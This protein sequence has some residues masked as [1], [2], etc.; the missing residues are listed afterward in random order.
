[1]RALLAAGLI[2]VNTGCVIPVA[3]SN[4]LAP[5]KKLEQNDVEVAFAVTIDR[6]IATP[7]QR[8]HAGSVFFGAAFY[9]RYAATDW[10]ALEAD[11]T[12]SPLLP[13]AIP[14]FNGVGAGA[15][16]TAVHD[17]DVK[18]TLEVAPRI[19]RWTGSWSEVTLRNTTIPGGEIV[20]LG[21]EL[22]LVGSFRPVEGVT[23]TMAPFGRYLTLEETRNDQT[24]PDRTGKAYGVGVS[25]S[26]TFLLGVF[27]IA[28]G[29]AIERSFFDEESPG[30]PAAER[31]SSAEWAPEPILGIGFV[32]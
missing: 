25:L 4:R 24:N 28:P 8:D 27:E 19:V 7:L 18:F 31:R 11:L 6:I 29:I 17:P 2:V 12:M 15:R 3:S 5:G 1:M 13:F 22:S 16:F 9:G 14:I 10:L 26:A 20:V 32:F 23:L 21:G 30:V